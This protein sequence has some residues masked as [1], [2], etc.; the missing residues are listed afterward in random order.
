MEYPVKQIG[1]KHLDWIGLIM[2]T[3]L[4]SYAKLLAHTL[5]TYM[6]RDQD[7]AWPSLSRI[8]HETSLSRSTACKYLTLLEEEGWLIRERGNLGKNTR[9]IIGFPMVIEKALGSASR[10]LASTPHALGSASHELEVVRD[11]DTN[12]PLNQPSNQPSTST[13]HA[14]H[15]DLPRLTIPQV[16]NLYHEKLP[17]LPRVQK[18]TKTREGLIR[19]RI[20]EDMQTAEQWENYF[21]HVANSDFL[22]GKTQPTNGRP[23]FRADLEWLCRPANLAKVAEDKYHVQQTKG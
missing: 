10:E 7:M 3:E 17:T 2:S 18:V 1:I 9:Y 8:E 22:M 13:S 5:A 16:I 12:Q 21:D 11:T 6:N 20:R 23:P 15:S 19:Q 4:P 14:T